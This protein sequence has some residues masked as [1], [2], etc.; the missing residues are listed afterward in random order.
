VPSLDFRL[1]PRIESM[2]RWV[3]VFNTIIQSRQALAR[4][5]LTSH[6]ETTT[7]DGPLADFIRLLND[8]YGA[9]LTYNQG[10]VLAM[11]GIIP[12]HRNGAGT[13]WRVRKDALPEVAA[14]LGLSAPTT[15]PNADGGPLAAGSHGN[16]KTAD[17]GRRHN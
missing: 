13:R 4:L 10:L 3:C 1:N 15:A 2:A 17:Y 16:K 6:P 14:K 7:M 11:R 9:D 8:N 12:A 5:L